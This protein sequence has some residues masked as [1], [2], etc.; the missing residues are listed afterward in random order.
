VEA[1]ASASEGAVSAGKGRLFHHSTTTAPTDFDALDKFLRENKHK[2]FVERFFYK[3]LPQMSMMNLE[4]TIF[5]RLLSRK[6][7][8]QQFQSPSSVPTDAANA[9]LLGSVVEGSSHAD[10]AACEDEVD[11]DSD[12]SGKSFYCAMF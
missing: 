11:G 1:A 6:K 12:E 9:Q 5:F 2:R 3:L 7:R 4:F 8:S 10:N